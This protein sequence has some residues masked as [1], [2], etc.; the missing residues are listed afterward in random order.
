MP[1][2]GFDVFT[3]AC[4]TSTGTQA[5]AGSC[6]GSTPKAAIVIVTRAT[7][8]GTVTDGA[9][10]SI[11][12]TDGTIT[13]A[14]HAVCEDGG[15]V[16]TYNTVRRSETA[17]GTILLNDTTTLDGSFNFSSFS[18]DTLT[19]DITDAPSTAVQML[20]ILFFGDDLEVKCDDLALNAAI[21]GVAAYSS[22]SFRPRAIFALHA[23]AG[24]VSSGGHARPSCGVCTFDDDAN[25]TKRQLSWCFVDRDTP[26]TITRVAQNVRNDAIVQRLLN[27]DSGAMTETAWYEVTAQ[28]ANGFDVTTRNAALGGPMPFLA[29]RFGSSRAWCGFPSFASSSTA[30]QGITEPGFRPQFVMAWGTGHQEANVNT[31][32]TGVGEMV[33]QVTIGASGA[34]GSDKQVSFQTEQGTAIGDTRCLVSSKLVQLVGD[35]GATIWDATL[36]SFD[37]T[38]P[39]IDVGT[40]SGNDKLMG[41][42]VVEANRFSGI[43]AFVAHRRANIHRARM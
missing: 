2:V 19:I 14:I 18:A 7:V 43:G 9:M 17:L 25:G 42:W 27:L 40:A 5:L 28:A 8:I 38:G 20:V 39:S 24:A 33:G 6:G 41:L 37:A 30:T 35:T 13:R 10:M 3:V 1:G 21:G 15:A 22:L 34:V 23:I 36:A 26:T 32:Q 29:F 11:G 16:A 31:L 12:I 4:N